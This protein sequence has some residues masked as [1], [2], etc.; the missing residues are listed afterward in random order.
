MSLIKWNPA[1]NLD[2]FGDFDSLMNDFFYNPRRRF[3]ADNAGWSPRMDVIERDGEYEL[4]AELP[5]M[6]KKDIDVS[7][8]DGV[9]TISGE[10]KYESE[11]ND[12]NCYCSE[13]RYGKFERS[14][15]MSNDISADDIKAEYKNG[16]LTLRVK[17]V[18]KP[19]EVSHKIAIK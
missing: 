9:L 7:V 18:D 4:S 2:L 19:E 8:K 12:D 11:K 16:I 10:K 17:K 1:R 6:E 15:R 14:F 5:G 13:R 3:N